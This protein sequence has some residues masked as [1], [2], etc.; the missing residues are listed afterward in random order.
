MAALRA[1]VAV[2]VLAEVTADA[3]PIV[4]QLTNDGAEPAGVWYIFDDGSSQPPALVMTLEPGQSSPLSTF[5]GHRLFWSAPPDAPGDALA[6]ARRGRVMTMP[7]PGAPAAFSLVADAPSAGERRL[8]RADWY[9]E[10]T[11][12]LIDEQRL[13]VPRLT[14]RGY[15]VVDFPDRALFDAM[16]E[17]HRAQA[18]APAAEVAANPRAARLVEPWAVQ[19]SIYGPALVNYEAVA[20][21]LTPAPRELSRAAQAALHPLVELFARG[22][23]DGPDAAA[24]AGGA[25]NATAG[26]DWRG[27]R[28]R[29]LHWV[30]TGTFGPREY[31]S[32]ATLA[33][34]VDIAAT[35]VISVVLHVGAAGG[36][37]AWPLAIVDHANATREI[38]LQPGEALLYESA[39]CAHGRPRP[40]AGDRYANWYAYFRP[41]EGW[42]FARAQYATIHEY[43]DTHEPT[44]TLPPPGTRLLRHSGGQDLPAWRLY[45]PRAEDAAA[46]L[47]RAEF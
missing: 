22:L 8:P 44:C 1:L 2:A 29:A 12:R 24:S 25:P 11:S 32:G 36:D 47:R 45:D 26:A 4:A 42:P 10:Y 43:C 35:N 17:A 46:A 18:A 30:G 31:G 13:V 28:A 19:G 3:I 5:E 39:R 21:H 20:T 6:A 40:F 9:R 16:V 37:A 27:E 15:A 14:E 33:M 38:V 23:L 34:H 7:A 41:A